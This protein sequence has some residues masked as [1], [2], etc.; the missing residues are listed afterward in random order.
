M[1]LRKASVLRGEETPLPKDYGLYAT[2]NRLGSTKDEN[3]AYWVSFGKLLA[4]DLEGGATREARQGAGPGAG[5]APS[6]PTAYDMS[7]VAA[8]EP[9]VAMPVANEALPGMAELE[10]L[11]A[12][13]ERGL[14]T[15]DEFSA[16][17]KRILGL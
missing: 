17:K 15:D 16:A 4:G 12:M 10:K 6:A 8:N 5:S 13:K 11:A 9:Q 1:A 14:L 3:I 2:T 7:R